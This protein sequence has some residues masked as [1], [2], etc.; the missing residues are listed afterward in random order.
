MSGR[1]Q[2][3]IGSSLSDGSNNTNKR[4][5][6]PENVNIVQA[7]VLIQKRA[8]VILYSSIADDYRGSFN[9]PRQWCAT[10]KRTF[11]SVKQSDNLD[12]CCNVKQAQVRSPAT[13]RDDFVKVTHDLYMRSTNRLSQLYQEI[14]C[15]K[16][17]YVVNW[18]SR[19]LSA[20]RSTSSLANHP[21]T[22]IQVNQWLC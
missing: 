9:F 5:S 13:D 7:E 4:P 11:N 3:F 1:N 10:A 15:W 21:E 16:G 14:L 22:S 12:S 17:L 2:D 18:W 19:L 20:P 8:Q 6:L